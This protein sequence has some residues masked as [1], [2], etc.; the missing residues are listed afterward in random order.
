MEDMKT[1]NVD[2]EGLKKVCLKFNINLV[3]LFG[4]HASSLVPMPPRKV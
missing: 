4:S 3:I 2:K 1:I